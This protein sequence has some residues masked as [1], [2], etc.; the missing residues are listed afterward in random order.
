MTSTASGRPRA[1]DRLRPHRVVVVGHGMVGARFAEDLLLRS[2]AGAPGRS[3]DVLVLGAEPYPAYNRL[4]LTEVLAGRADL[5]SLGLPVPDDPR[6]RVLPGSAATALDLD[7][8]VVTD[9]GGREHGFDTLVLATGADPRLPDV[10]GLR[11]ADGGLPPGAHALRTVDDCRE[12]LAA[13]GNVRTAVVVGGGLLGLEAA[14][15]LRHRGLDVV[16]V[17]AGSHLMDRQLPAGGGAALAAAADDLGVGSRCGRRPT[18]VHRTPDGRV[19]AVELDDGEVLPAGL[20]VVAAGVAPRTALAEAAGLPCGRGVVVGADLRSPADRRVAAVGDCAE[21]PDGCPGLLAPGWEQAGRLAGDLARELAGEP[22]GEHAATA[23]EDGAPAGV[24]TGAGPGPA[25]I[26]LKATGLDVVTCGDTTGSGLRVLTVGDPT[27]R[28]Y[29]EVALDPGGA[30]AGVVA[31]GAGDVAPR[32][33]S[34]VEH[35]GP[36]PQDPLHLLL[37]TAAA[38]PA[39]ASSPVHMPPGATVCR[40][41]GVTKRDLV[42]AWEAGAGD[43]DAVAAATRATTGCGGC[44]EAVCGLLDWLHRSEGE[45]SSQPPATGGERTVTTAERAAHSAGTAAGHAAADG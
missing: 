30:L 28:R 5:T 32:L 12:V 2:P 29:V 22:A 10:P 11:T 45:P 34:L 6:L 7:R 3:L 42:G 14:R 9:E 35:G 4:L 27:A 24:P 37:P 15:G 38:G 25:P 16:V 8:G 33:A 31:V 39:P 44:R 36:V 41:N 19:A 13:C 21:T 17:H 18:H 1:A 23:H 40:C 26:R 20:L 43:V